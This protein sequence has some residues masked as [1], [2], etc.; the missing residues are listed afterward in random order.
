MGGE[1]QVLAAV[2][3]TSH[4]SVMEQG[5]TTTPP[6]GRSSG[7]QMFLQAILHVYEV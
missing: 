7:L 6:P 1:K 2:R 3:P 4:C 5:D